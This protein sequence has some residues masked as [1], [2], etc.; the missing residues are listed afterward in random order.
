MEEEFQ[1]IQ[2]FGIF[3]NEEKIIEKVF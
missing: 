1:K 2:I 3:K